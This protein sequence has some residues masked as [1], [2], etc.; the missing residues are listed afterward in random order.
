M[1]HYQMSG[2]IEEMDI[3][4][5]QQKTHFHVDSKF[6]CPTY[7]SASVSLFSR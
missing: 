5:W 2:P 4:F 7:V 3:L 6:N 1:L